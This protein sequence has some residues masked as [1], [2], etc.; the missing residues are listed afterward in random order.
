MQRHFSHLFMIFPLHNVR[1]TDGDQTAAVMRASANW[2]AHYN[3]PNGFSKVGTCHGRNYH[4]KEMINQVKPP[5]CH[6]FGWAGDLLMQKGTR[7][8]VEG[9]AL[10]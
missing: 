10:D 6:L 8:T 2:Y 7:I 3:P 5:T 9:G 4:T 1:S